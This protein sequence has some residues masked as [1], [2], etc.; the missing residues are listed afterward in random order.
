MMTTYK[1]I[2]NGVWDRFGKSLL[3]SKGSE[4]QIDFL[5]SC[6]GGKDSFLK[7]LDLTLFDKKDAIVAGKGIYFN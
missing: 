2:D 5:Q 4:K 7:Y 6:R 3:S 1:E